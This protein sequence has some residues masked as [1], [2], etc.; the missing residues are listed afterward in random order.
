MLLEAATSA[1]LRT[2]VK[3]PLV[4]DAMEMVPKLKSLGCP[5]LMTAC[6]NAQLMV[7]SSAL[8][9]NYIAPF[10]ARI[11]ENGLPADEAKAQMLA[12]EAS[13]G[14]KTRKLVASLRN[15]EQLCRLSEMECTCFT[16]SSALVS[17]LTADMQSENAVQEFELAAKGLSHSQFDP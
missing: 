8:E 7:I 4:P 10:F 17:E 15:S 13:T 12:V 3:V 9:A 5:I 16:L 11:L 14:Y 1:N 2:V 6:Y